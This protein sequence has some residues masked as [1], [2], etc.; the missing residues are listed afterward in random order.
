M[1]QPPD[2]STFMV[3]T[4]PDRLVWDR[5]CRFMAP[6]VLKF[7]LAPFQGTR[8]AGFETDAPTVMTLNH[9]ARADYGREQLT[10]SPTW[11]AY[12]RMHPA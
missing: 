2:R 4:L 9:D 11:I 1:L 6:P 8:E 3:F 7:Y 5:T 12:G 10:Q